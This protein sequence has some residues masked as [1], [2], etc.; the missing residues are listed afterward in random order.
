MATEAPR[1]IEEK[2][3][4]SEINVLKDVVGSTAEAFEKLSHRLNPI[5]SQPEEGKQIGTDEN[6]ICP[7][8]HE[9]RAERK[10]LQDLRSFIQDVIGRLQV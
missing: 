5:C 3:V 8:A 7:L 9:V 2:E 10:K 6:E 4:I 1:T